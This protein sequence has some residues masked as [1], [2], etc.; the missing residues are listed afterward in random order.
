MEWN[1]LDWTWGCTGDTAIMIDC[2]AFE[3]GYDFTGMA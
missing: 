1:E 2:D 3:E